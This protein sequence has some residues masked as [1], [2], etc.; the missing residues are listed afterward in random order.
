MGFR[1]D[2][3]KSLISVIISHCDEIQY[4]DIAETNV[5][6]STRLAGIH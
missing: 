6:D 2:I 1:H 5:A 4:R 3:A